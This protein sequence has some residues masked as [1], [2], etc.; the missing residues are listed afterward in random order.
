MP[1]HP[2]T[3]PAAA[4][5]ASELFTRIRSLIESARSTIARGV[6]LVQVHTNFEI[7][8]HIVEFEQQGEERAAY[9]KAVLQQLAERL[10]TE[11][12]SGFSVTNLKLMRQFY[13]QYSPRISQTLS[14]PSALHTP[15]SIGQT[16][17]GLLGADIGKRPFNLS[18]SHYV[19]LLGIKNAEERS[20]YEIES[21]Q[22]NW[23]LRDLRR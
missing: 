12:G 8:R 10:S 21:T 2:R 17:S 13:V 7:G 4:D 11:F 3:A 23:T 16:L 15:G 19:F 14:D 6:D 9:G 5:P 22:Q 1:K 18:W 20:F